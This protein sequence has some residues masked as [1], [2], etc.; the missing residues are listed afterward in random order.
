MKTY[1]R[2]SLFVPIPLHQIKLRQRGFNHA[3]LLSTELSLYFGNKSQALLIRHKPTIS[4]FGL[5]REKRKENL[6]K[7]FRLRV[8]PGV[9]TV[10]LV[11]DIVT[12]GTTFSEAAKV[13]KRGGVEKVYGIALAHGR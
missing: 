10:F 3:E 2:D 6:T 13:L 8:K 4:Q 9:K 5:T 11:D 12:T 1:S 7:A